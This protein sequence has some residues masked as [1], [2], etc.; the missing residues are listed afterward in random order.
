MIKSNF[1]WF[2][3]LG[4]C[5]L[6]GFQNCSSGFRS[7]GAVDANSL[8]T[9]DVLGLYYFNTLGS[10][11]FISPTNTTPAT[12]LSL[13]VTP[14]IAAHTIAISQLAPSTGVGSACV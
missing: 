2:T 12:G 5:L 11:A 1:T 13:T 6:L 4:A 14:N 3:L 9:P 8:S 10:I 7:G